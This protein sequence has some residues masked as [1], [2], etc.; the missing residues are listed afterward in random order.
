MSND[1]DN[2]KEIYWPWKVKKDPFQPP[3]INTKAFITIIIRPQYKKMSY[4]TTIGNS[5]SH[6]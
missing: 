5:K 4:K 3:I 2:N 1:Y 6:T